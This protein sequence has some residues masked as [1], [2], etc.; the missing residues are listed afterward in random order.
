MRS[1]LATWIPLLTAALAGAGALTTAACGQSTTPP[2]GPDA[3]SPAATGRSTAPFPLKCVSQST[4]DKRLP[5]DARET[6][7][8]FVRA[9][10]AGAP[11]LVRAWLAPASTAEIVEGLA[12]VDR[13]GLLALQDRY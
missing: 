11:G 13:L 6:V 2:S 7:R 5:A 8:R 4:G 12:G 3:T 1:S 10:D 9:V